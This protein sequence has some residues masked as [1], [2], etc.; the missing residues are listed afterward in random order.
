MDL[1]TWETVRAIGLGV[2][3]FLGWWLGCWVRARCKAC[4][5][6]RRDRAEWRERMRGLTM[7]GSV[8]T[9]PAE[10]EENIRRKLAKV[11]RRG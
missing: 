7:P 10:A 9:A 6:R 3:L 2:G 11:F 8:P 4:W 1:A 5:Q